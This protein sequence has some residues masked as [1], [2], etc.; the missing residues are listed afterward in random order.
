MHTCIAAIWT[1]ENDRETW[2][3]FSSSTWQQTQ[4]AFQHFGFV[5]VPRFSKQSRRLHKKPIMQR[6]LGGPIGLGH[7]AEKTLRA[8][9]PIGHPQLIRGE[10]RIQ[11]GFCEQRG[12]QKPRGRTSEPGVECELKPVHDQAELDLYEPFKQAENSSI[13]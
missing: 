12:Q 5:S 3:L 10:F 7:F 8:P 13:W 11:L 4:C 2:Y 9:E 1:L 6:V